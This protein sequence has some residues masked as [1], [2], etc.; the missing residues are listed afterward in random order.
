M[1]SPNV[2]YRSVIGGNIMAPLHA[3][4]LIAAGRALR[5]VRSAAR[6]RAGAELRASV[7]CLQALESG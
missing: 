5:P 6:Y 2:G 3:G 7:P 1:P 4:P